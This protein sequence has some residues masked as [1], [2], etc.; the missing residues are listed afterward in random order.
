[1]YMLVLYLTVFWMVYLYV[2]NFFLTNRLLHQHGVDWLLP[3]KLGTKRALSKT[4]LHTPLAYPHHP[5]ATVVANK[6]A[7]FVIAHPDDEC[8]FF[9]PTVSI[10]YPSLPHLLTLRFFVR[11]LVAS[12]PIMRFTCS[13]YPPATQM[14]W[15]S[16]D[17]VNYM[18][19]RRC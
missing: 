14:A 3:V 17:L 5:S 19:H 6:V 4:T 2:R 8:L 15:A 7:L 1:M 13:V 11:S 9:A 18:P 12:P 10:T 16:G